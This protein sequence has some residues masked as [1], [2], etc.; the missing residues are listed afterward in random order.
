MGRKSGISVKF[1]IEDIGH[2]KFVIPLTHR[3]I[4]FLHSSPLDI[5]DDY[6]SANIIKDDERHL[7][8]SFKRFINELEKSEP[9]YDMVV[10]VVDG[11]C[12]GFRG[13][14]AEFR[15]KINQNTGSQTEWYSLYLIH[16]LRGGI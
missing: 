5:K 3:I 16:T 7:K 2:K 13:R 1:F 4:K 15:R 9:L 14:R 11:N 10:I 12:K 6:V 8:K